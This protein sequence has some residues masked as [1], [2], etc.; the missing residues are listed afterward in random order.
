MIE[1]TVLIEAMDPQVLVDVNGEAQLR[2]VADDSVA[3]ETASGDRFAWRLGCA[4]VGAGRSRPRRS[5]VRSD[6]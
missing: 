3:I 2:P 4:D 6:A 1:D 5:S